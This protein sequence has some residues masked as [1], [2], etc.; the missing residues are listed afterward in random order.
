MY[1]RMHSMAMVLTLV[2]L[3]LPGA[4]A[5]PAAEDSAREMAP[6]DLTGQWVSIITE[7][8]R[9]R[10][11]TAQ[12]GDY[13][14][15]PLS[16]AGQE[17]ADSWNPP[18]E[19]RGRECKAFGVGGLMRMPTRLRIDWQDE[20]VLRIRTDN[21]EQTRLLRFDEAQNEAGAGTLQGISDARWEIARQGGVDSPAVSGTLWVETRDMREGYVRRNGVPYSDQTTIT[22][23]FELLHHGDTDYLVVITRL[24]D[25]VYMTS[26]VITS[27]NFKR[28]ERGS[29]NWDPRPCLD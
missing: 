19:Q 7:D 12:A 8:W 23:H 18:A 29:G 22:E 17:L 4:R 16:Q 25:P 28:E 6:I 13:E 14:G 26:E 15:L 24:D 1:S 2:F 21:G 11:I 9:F 10:M 3:V 20:D 27:T 5:Q